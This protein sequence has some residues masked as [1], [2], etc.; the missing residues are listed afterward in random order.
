VLSGKLLPY[1][2]IIPE[3]AEEVFLAPGSYVI[4][5]VKLHQG[6]SIWYSTVVRGDLE[7]IVIGENTNIQDN[8]TVHVGVSKPTKIGS[9]VSVGH[10]SVIHACTIED[11]CLI[12]MNAAVMDGAHIGEG[13][14]I[15]AG[16]V[17]SPGS[18]IPPYSIVVGMPGKVIKS[19]EPQEAREARIKQAERYLRAA[20]KHREMLQSQ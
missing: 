12:G 10:G 16:A 2:G 13:C 20:G 4:G 14:V 9:F 7:S 15:G 6:V 3:A 8:C 1:D 5:K 19:I 17:V 11:Y 18:V